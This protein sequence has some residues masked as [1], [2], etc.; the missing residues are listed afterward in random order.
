MMQGKIKLRELYPIHIRIKMH[1]EY[2]IVML[3]ILVKLKFILVPFR[4]ITTVT[5]STA[6]ILI[7]PIWISIK[8]NLGSLW[9]N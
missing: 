7:F 2:Q 1:S 8:Y 6:V 9:S 4:D 3:A 5:L